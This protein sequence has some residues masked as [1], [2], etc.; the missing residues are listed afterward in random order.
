MTNPDGKSRL[1]AAERAKRDARIFDLF[2]AGA[3]YRQIAAQ[4]GLSSH[5]SVHKVIERELKA[6]GKRRSLLNSSAA[7]VFI[8]RTEALFRANF[9]AALR[10]DYKAAVI[11][12]RILA[13]QSRF[14][15]LDVAGGS[16]PPVEPPDSPIDGEDDEE[17][18]DELA[19]F[20]RRR[21]RGA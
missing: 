13:R 19:R 5:S 7:D 10:G 12:D 18:G 8:E 14:S 6:A 17:G 1:T 15:G 2:L 20:R 21:T 16:A 11:C 4:T 3:T 9:A